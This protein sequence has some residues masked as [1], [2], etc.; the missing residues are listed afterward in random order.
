MIRQTSSI[1]RGIWLDVGRSTSST[2]R[3]GL[4]VVTAVGRFVGELEP[5]GADDVGQPQQA[6]ERSPGKRGPLDLGDRATLE[7]HDDSD[8]KRRLYPDQETSLAEERRRFERLEAH[9]DV[10]LVELSLEEA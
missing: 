8:I 7:T 3:G 10:P 6:R 4:A 9:W 2:T 1:Q 5:V